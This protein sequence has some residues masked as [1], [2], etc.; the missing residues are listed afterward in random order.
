MNKKI[1]IIIVLI[2]IPLFLSL[3]PSALGGDTDFLIVSGNSMLPTILPGSLVITKEAPSYQID[4]IVAYVQREGSA[5]MNVVHRIIDVTDKGFIIKGDN[6]PKK[7]PGFPTSDDITGKV[8]FA[9]PYVGD[10]LGMM[11]N[12]IVFLLTSVV[13]IIIQ[14]EQKRRK[15]KK[16]RSTQINLG[17]RKKTGSLEQNI[18]TKPKKPDYG[19]FFAAIALNVLT[20][21]GMQISTISH[22]SP[23]GDIL[24]GFLFKMLLP[25]LASTISFALY[26]VFII[27]LYFLAKV[28][29]TKTF[30]S[31]AGSKRKSAMRLLFGK[32]SNPMLA[33][34]SFF[35]FLFILMSSFHLLAIVKDLV[36]IF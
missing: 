29:E 2:F 13:A 4:D 17:T 6:N 33:L 7:D 16:E 11:R 9:T 3:R 5:Q 21:V 34:A 8:I 20:Y 18:Q 10:I 19:L 35:W 15:M 23:K 36:T 30:D 27:G 25:S 28:Y 32:K 24:T 14:V 1:K 12:P 22:I 26:F 31:Q